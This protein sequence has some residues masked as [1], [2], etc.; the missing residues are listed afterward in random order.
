M[1]RREEI[2]KFIANAQTPE[3]LELLL[4][5]CRDVAPQYETDVRLLQS[6][7]SEITKEEIMGM[8]IDRKDSIRLRAGILELSTLIEKE[9]NVK[10]SDEETSSLETSK[11]QVL[12]WNLESITQVNRSSV[13]R[14]V[15]FT[16][17]LALV[18]VAIYVY[19]HSKFDNA[20][21]KAGDTVQ[22]MVSIISILPAI[23]GLM[24]LKDVNHKLDLI[25]L[26]ETYRKRIEQ[27]LTNTQN[28]GPVHLEEVARIN[29]LV[30]KIQESSIG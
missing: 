20:A 16:L 11:L 24:P 2:H 8:E 12:V 13:R 29:L 5:Y 3:A 4:A 6:Q 10:L 14:S 26:C 7:Q 22:T 30:N 19:Y 1:N 21:D 28:I 15:A 27:L 9:S 17:V 23:L 18:S 25:K